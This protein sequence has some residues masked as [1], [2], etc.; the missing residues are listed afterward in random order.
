MLVKTENEKVKKM[1]KE[2]KKE[3]QDYFYEGW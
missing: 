2:Y 3:M 1:Q